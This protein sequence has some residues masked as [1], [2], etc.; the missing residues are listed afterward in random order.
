MRALP[1]GRADRR[2]LSTGES[3]GRIT[4]DPT[5][6]WRFTSGG[7]LKKMLLCQGVVLLLLLKDQMGNVRQY[8]DGNVI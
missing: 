1:A 2:E 3:R 6:S 4:S 7:I 5:P 8:G